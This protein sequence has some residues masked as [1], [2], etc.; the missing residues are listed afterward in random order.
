MVLNMV[1]DKWRSILA[2]RRCKKDL[3]AY[4][5]DDMLNL[6]S[7]SLRPYQQFI[8]NTGEEAFSIAPGS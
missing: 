5:A 2:W 3:T 8:T 1:P 6:I 4:I 7:L